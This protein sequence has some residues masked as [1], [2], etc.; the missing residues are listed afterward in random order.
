MPIVGDALRRTGD[1]LTEVGER[2]GIDWLTYNPLRMVHF[3]RAARR[4]ARPFVRA[5]RTAC[6]DARSCVDV[7]CGSGAY[8]AEATRQGL[9]AI[10][11]ERSRAG[12]L[13]ARLQGADARPF[14]LTRSPPTR[15]TG[16]FDVAY[17]IE[18]A[19]HL[20]PELGDRLVDV[21]CELAPLVVFSAATPG[22]GGIGH[23]NEQPP[24]YWERR[25]R[26]RGYEF[27]PE[28]T[29][30]LLAVLD[31]HGTDFWLFNSRVFA[32]A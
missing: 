3:H 13:I 15:V 30:R 21:V 19:E 4:N 7:G 24:E 9:D 14:D 29:G 22:Q 27:L 12:R 32:R 5:L 25:F 23:I 6:P 31:E 17:S 1:A 11:C 8:V 18:V 2:R 16:P 26:E 10:G 20:P 28:P